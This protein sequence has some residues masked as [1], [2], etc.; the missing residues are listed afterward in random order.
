MY[1]DYPL[2][3]SI[4]FLLKSSFILC[5][6]REKSSLGTKVGTTQ[7]CLNELAK[8]VYK[9]FILVSLYYFVMVAHP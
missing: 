4:D 3:V 5:G 1:I 6:L 2:K 8:I 9:Y 7:P